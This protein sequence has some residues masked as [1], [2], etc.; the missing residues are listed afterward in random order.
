MKF[1]SMCTRV[2]LAAGVVY[3]SGCTVTPAAP[4]VYG[5]PPAP[6]AQE[7]LPPLPTFPSLYDCERAYGLGACGTGPQ[8]YASASLVAPPF[9]L[10]WYMPFEYAAL[11][12]ALMYAHLAPPTVFVTSIA[13]RSYLAPVYVTRYRVVTPQVIH[14]YKALPVR[15]REHYQRFGP[16]PARS[17]PGLA[18]HAP[19]APPAM[20]DRRLAPPGPAAVPP[21]ASEPPRRAM[22]RP[23]QAERAERAQPERAAPPAPAARAPEAQ[24]PEPRTRRERKDKNERD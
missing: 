18:P 5:P 15:E 23:T 3:L 14:H 20:H 9:V 8:V 2:L 12:G 16:P 4:P 21:P 11:T 19:P 22:P 13:Y 7:A 17:G 1:T 6:Y 10:G 24:R